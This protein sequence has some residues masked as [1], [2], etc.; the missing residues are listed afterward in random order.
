M[1]LRLG[2]GLSRTRASRS[3]LS[4]LRRVLRRIGHHAR[5]RH[6]ERARTRGAGGSRRSRLPG[7]FARRGATDADARGRVRARLRRARRDAR[8][9]A[10]R[11]RRAARRCRGYRFGAYRRALPRW[12][13]AIARSARSSTFSRTAAV[14][15][16]DRGLR[17]GGERPHAAATTSTRRARSR[18]S[19]RPYAKH[20]FIGM[21]H[22]STASVLKT[23][24][25]CSCC[26]RSRSAICSRATWATSSQQVPTCVRTT[27]VPPGAVERRGAAEPGQVLQAWQDVR[28][29]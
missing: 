27:A 25:A 9:A 1:L 26:R 18:S 10:F 8:R 20:G 23:S 11:L 19:F 16:H 24:T 17:V 15:A 12:P 4:G 3:D 5:R 2:H 21:R 22:L 7:V 13:T 6:A 29:W 28:S 14:V